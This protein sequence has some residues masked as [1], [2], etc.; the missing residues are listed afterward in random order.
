MVEYV[1]N[2]NYV[3]SLGLQEKFCK[4]NK[5]ALGSH[6]QAETFLKIENLRSNK[7]TGKLS[8]LLYFLCSRMSR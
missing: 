5:T 8:K 3:Q 1:K 4:Q 7:T 6:G 2:V